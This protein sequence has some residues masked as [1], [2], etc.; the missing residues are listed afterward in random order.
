MSQKYPPEN[1]PLKTDVGHEIASLLGTSKSVEVAGGVPYNVE[2]GNL[3][4]VPNM[5]PT[6]WPT[7]SEAAAATPKPAPLALAADLAGI[8]PTLEQC[9]SIVVIG[10]EK[11][12]RVFAY[13]HAGTDP[14]SLAMLG[15]LE[16]I[17]RDILHR[18][19]PMTVVHGA[20]PEPDHAK[21]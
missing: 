21:D 1:V 6:P 5:K 19:V 4:G 13:R 9:T 17:K 7:K 3:S 2:I 14:H 18:E 16:S 11:D 8:Y 12:G 10:I 15:A 20:S